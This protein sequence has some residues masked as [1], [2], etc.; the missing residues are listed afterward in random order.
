M[1]GLSRCR[2]TPWTAARP[3]HQVACL[4]CICSFPPINL[5]KTAVPPKRHRC[6]NNGPGAPWRFFPG[7]YR[8]HQIVQFTRSKEQRCVRGNL[9]IYGEGTTAAA[10]KNLQKLNQTKKYRSSRNQK[11]TNLVILWAR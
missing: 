3:F 9:F 7:T 4:Q 1:G 10:R 11:T 8:S 2:N 5:F 6:G